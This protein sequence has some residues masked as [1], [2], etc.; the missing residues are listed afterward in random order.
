M[1]LRA[2]KPSNIKA[3]NCELLNSAAA[4]CGDGSRSPNKWEAAMG[5]TKPHKNENGQDDTCVRDKRE[6]HKA[7]KRA[8]AI[9]NEND[10]SSHYTC[11]SPISTMMHPEQQQSKENR[12]KQWCSQPTA[13]PFATPD[14]NNEMSNCRTKRCKQERT[15]LKLRPR[16]ITQ[17]QSNKKN[18]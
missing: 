8:C 1:N 18:D 10:T 16:T 17:Q 9:T 2:S 6:T 13:A 3:A 12:K 14:A 7:C 15:P 11:S 4:N 5:Q